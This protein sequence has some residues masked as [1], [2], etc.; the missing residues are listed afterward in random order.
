MVLLV[1]SNISATYKI[2]FLDPSAILMFLLFGVVPPA[3]G[4]F[5]LTQ[6][7]KWLVVWQTLYV[8]D[9]FYE[10]FIAYVGANGEES[11]GQIMLLPLPIFILVGIVDEAI[12]RV[13]L[14][15][16]PAGQYNK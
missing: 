7:G 5:G 9:V 6:F 12:Y 10:V 1:V 14:S 8:P 15:R 11:L 13:R 2:N 4:F 16:K 3:L